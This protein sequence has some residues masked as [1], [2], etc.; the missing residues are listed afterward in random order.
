MH[1]NIT[2]PKVSSKIANREIKAQLEIMRG[3]WEMEV[4]K[5]EAA[6]IKA[7]SAHDL[8][9]EIEHLRRAMKEGIVEREGVQCE[10]AKTKIELVECQ[11][12]F[13]QAVERAEEHLG[14]LNRIAR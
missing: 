11:Q 4:R 13:K 3:R 8:R 10:L 6:E 5:R 1:K 9:D 12:R 2:K 7:E 14:V